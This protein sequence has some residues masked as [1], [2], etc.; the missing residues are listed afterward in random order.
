MN[1]GVLYVGLGLGVAGIAFIAWRYFNTPSQT[2]STTSV[3]PNSSPAVGNTD[4]YPF[5]NSIPARMDNSSQPW[6]NNNR[7]ILA[8]S[9]KVDDNLQ[10][11][12]SVAGYTK[13]IN[14]LA[15]DGGALWDSVSSWFDS[16]DDTGLFSD[17]E[18]YD[19][20]WTFV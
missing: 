11:L 2:F 7:S 4:G 12:N 6:F 13:A 17:T 10:F 15:E 14:T 19:G 20:D 1:K 3:N 8:A 9:P 18:M 16:G 5:V